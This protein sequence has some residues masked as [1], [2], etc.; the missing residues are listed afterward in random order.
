MVETGYLL[1][2]DVDRKPVEKLHISE[3]KKI[4]YSQDSK[5]LIKKLVSGKGPNSQGQLTPRSEKT[6][7]SRHTLKKISI[8]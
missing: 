4:I 5:D 3:V 1:I 6:I 7:I 8:F 2:S